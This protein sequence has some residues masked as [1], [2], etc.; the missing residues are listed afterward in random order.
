M[1]E[2]LAERTID[3]SAQLSPELLAEERQLKGRLAGNYNR[4]LEARSQPQRDERQIDQ[5][6]VQCVRS[7]V[8]YLGGGNVDA[9]IPVSDARS[10]RRPALRNPLA[11]IASEDGGRL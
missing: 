2:L 4:L 8:A 11:G 1:A 9:E 3:T 10:R 7:A 5:L 6:A